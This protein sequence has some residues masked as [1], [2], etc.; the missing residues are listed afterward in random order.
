MGGFPSCRRRKKKVGRGG[1]RFS[2]PK[3]KGGERARAARSVVASR[4]EEEGANSH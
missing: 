1:R 2:E 4:G 3:I